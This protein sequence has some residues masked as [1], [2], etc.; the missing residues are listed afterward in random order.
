MACRFVIDD[1]DAGFFQGFFHGG[2]LAGIAALPHDGDRGAFRNFKTG[3]EFI[4]ERDAAVGALGD[5]LNVF[6]FTVWADHARIVT[7]LPAGNLFL[8]DLARDFPGAQ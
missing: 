8:S 5:A 6:A 7:R 3:I 4:D 1:R 2:A